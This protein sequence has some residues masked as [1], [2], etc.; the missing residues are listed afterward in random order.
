MNATASSEAD[1]RVFSLT[2]GV[3]KFDLCGHSGG[4]HRMS[5]ETG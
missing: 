1:F 5:A 3:I 4:R 2:N